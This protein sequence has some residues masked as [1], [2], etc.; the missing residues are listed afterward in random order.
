MK[1]SLAEAK[2]AAAGF[3]ESVLTPRDRC[4]AVAFSSRPSLLM[5]PTP[6][7]KALEIAFRD[8]PALGS[9]A[10]HD[11]LVY[12]LYQFRG[13]R[14]R[15]AMVVLSDG[16]DTA[17]L[18]PFEDAL[19]FA[20]RSGAAIYTVGLGIGKSAFGIRGKLQQLAEETGGRV[21]YVEQAS[22]LFGVYEEIELELRSQYFVAFAPDPPPKEG[23]RH[24]IEVEARGGKL[25][26]RSARGYTP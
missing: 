10:L 12:S 23:E 6:D 24:V 15:K 14:G 7:A 20:Q 19:T 22:E 5:P 9:T 8:L 11:A 25:K 18:V 21:F 1:E 13:V 17:S 3:L 16:E 2:R 4:F 26:A